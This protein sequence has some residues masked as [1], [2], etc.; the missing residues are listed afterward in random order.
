MTAPAITTD[1]EARNDGAAVVRLTWPV[2]DQ[3][4]SDEEW[5]VF[6]DGQPVDL[7][8]GGW[9]TAARA[10]DRRDADRTLASWSSATTD[11]AAGGQVVIGAADITL[12][13]A[14]T[15]TTSTVRLRHSPT[16]SAGWGPFTGLVD[17]Q[18]TRSVD[19]HVT[20]RRTIVAGTVRAEQDVTP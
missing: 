2:G 4:Q 19:G 18:I 1:G 17:L 10:C 16:V 12:P 13:D 3:W 20:D 14:T 9:T 6:V 15:V 8:T 7:T 5:A 11:P